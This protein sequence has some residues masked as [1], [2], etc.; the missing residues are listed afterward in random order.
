[1]MVI[2][3]KPGLSK[4]FF[5]ILHHDKKTGMTVGTRHRTRESPDVNTVIDNNKIKQVHNQ[6]LLDIYIDENLL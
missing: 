3:L 2:S 5:Y 4:I 1:M 6:I